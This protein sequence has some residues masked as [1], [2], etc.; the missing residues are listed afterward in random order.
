MNKQFI[1]TLLLGFAGFFSNGFAQNNNSNSPYTRYGYG[2]L[3]DPSSV[4]M[5]GMGGI[6]FGLRNSQVINP[7]NPAAVSAVDSMT[8]M[9]DV[10]LKLQTEQFNDQGNRASKTSGG[11]EYAS[12]QFPLAKRLGIGLGLEPVSYIGYKFGQSS[13]DRNP[14]SNNT[15]IGSETYSGSGGINRIYANLGYEVW[16][17]RLSVGVKGA[18]VFG[19]KNHYTVYTP[20]YS[21]QAPLSWPDSLHING[22]MYEA[23]LQYRQ[24]IDKN[25]EVI[26][27]LVYKPKTP[28]STQL[29]RHETTGKVF[30]SNDV[31]F[32]MPET[33]GIGFTY[34]CLNKLTAGADFQY[35]R[36]ANVQYYGKTDTLS[37]RMKINVGLEYTPDKNSKR[38]LGRV[39]YRIGGYYTDSYFTDSNGSKCKEVGLNLGL[40]IPMTDRRSFVNLAFEYSR[41]IPQSTKSLSESYFKFTVSYTLNELWFHKRKLQ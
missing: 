14:S 7:A 25:N 21:E 26:I 22:F 1:A 2:K 15:I 6:A 36:W 35:Q 19:E 9:L 32:E 29:I 27:G 5:Q 18:W 31:A 16:K 30:R 39:R 11:L 20:L 10:G 38:F 33:F 40:G 24:P 37:N 13:T 8:F 34:N 12:L 28:L 23:G 17:N 41:L 4:A 3:A